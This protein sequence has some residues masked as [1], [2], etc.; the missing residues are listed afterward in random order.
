MHCVVGIDKNILEGFGVGSGHLGE[1]SFSLCNVQAM[2]NLCAMYIGI[3]SFINLAKSLA[4]E[5]KELFVG[6]LLCAAVNDHVAKFGLLARLDLQLQ[7]LVHLKK[8]KN[9]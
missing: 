4:H 6:S 2:C 8:K 9:D 7:K 3:F 5:A 1:K